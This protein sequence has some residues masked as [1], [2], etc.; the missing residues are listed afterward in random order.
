MELQINNLVKRFGD[1]VALDIPGLQ[2]E[3]GTLLGLVGNNGAGKTTLFRLILDLLKADAGHV[4][5]KGTD[6]S[7][8]ED[9]KAYTGSFID[10]RFLI[11]FLTPEEYFD[12][13][14][15]TYGL[16]K[17]DLQERLSPFAR[18]MN[19]EILGQKKYIRNFSAGN[20]QKIGIIAAMMIQPEVLILD[21]PFNFLDPSS[22]IEI[23]NMILKM[24]R[25][26]G[27]TVLISSHNLNYTTDISSRLVLLEK[28]IVL[29]D[30]NNSP[31]AIAE[32]NDY[33]IQKAEA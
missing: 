20:K 14:G 33:F 21:E 25:E 1:K 9:W 15:E 5:S 11:E 7:Q 26:Q 31:E 2:I 6:V 10:N 12:F 24:N 28:G 8:S 17:N 32:L 23:R 22:Q 30:R 3:K 16:G 29:K 27:T 13:V 18:F 19:G 4:L